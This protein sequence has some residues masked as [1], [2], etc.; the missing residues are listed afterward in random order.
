M[1]RVYPGEEKGGGGEGGVNKGRGR[2]FHTGT[3]TYTLRLAGRVR[4][5]SLSFRIDGA[6]ENVRNRFAKNPCMIPA[7]SLLSWRRG[8]GVAICYKTGLEHLL[9]PDLTT[10]ISPLWTYQSAEEQSL[11]SG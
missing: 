9:H 8:G 11:R 3:T 1:S 10:P 4:C 5:L 7:P 2:C 6:E